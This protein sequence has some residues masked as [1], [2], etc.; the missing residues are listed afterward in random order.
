MRKFWIFI[1]LVAVVFACYTFLKQQSINK[2]A[3]VYN[4]M[5]FQIP[6]ITFE[7]SKTEK[8]LQEDTT[9][10]K[11]NKPSD[12][13]SSSSV[14]RGI[15]KIVDLYDYMDNPHTEKGKEVLDELQKLRETPKETFEEIRKG[16]FMLSDSYETRKQFLVQYA[17]SLDVDKEEK[18]TFLKEGMER[19]LQYAQESTNVQTTYTPSVIFDT[20][21]NITEDPMEVEKF[22]TDMLPKSTTEIQKNMIA[23]YNRVN[24]E[25]ATELARKYS[26][27]TF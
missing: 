11:E 25:K 8:N 18:A 27:N 2:K 19:S 24:S 16:V 15:A 6:K 17:A 7:Q 9:Q 5:H 1:A 3:N 12:V 22:I 26:L 20:F 23:S 13:F 4:R 14:G 21:I 10:N